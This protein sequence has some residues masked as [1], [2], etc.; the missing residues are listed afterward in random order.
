MKKILAIVAIL[1]GILQFMPII[2]FPDISL[3]L[4]SAG[5]SKSINMF[6]VF[7]LPLLTL[8]S[9]VMAL[10]KTKIGL[11]SLMGVFSIY[12]IISVLGF[13]KLKFWEYLSTDYMPSIGRIELITFGN[14]I[15]FIVLLVLIYFNIFPSNQ[16]LNSTPKNGAS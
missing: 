10:F 16:R 14:C 3:A 9:G 7:L 6:V 13:A 5:T 11:I 2:H 1:F 15:F 8:T 12:F 4:I